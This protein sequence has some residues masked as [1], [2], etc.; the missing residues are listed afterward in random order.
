MRIKGPM[1]KNLLMKKTGFL[2][3]ILALICAMQACE[4]STQP[5]VQ[6]AEAMPKSPNDSLFAVNEGG[7]NFAIFLP[8]DLMIENEPEIRFNSATGDLHIRI[9]ER[10]WIVASQESKDISKLKEEINEN[11]LFTSRII[12]ETN[13]ALL[14]QR[15]L[16]DGRAYDYNYRYLS[17]IGGKPYF[18][19]TCEE[20]EYSKE[21]VDMMKSA[22]M[23]VHSRG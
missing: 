19:K 11:M 12:E 14:Y 9:G 21:S 22:I 3:T 18:F 23:S 16:P 5:A 17:S 10:F 1:N 2:L 6:Q 8:K 15:L 20:G 13:N 7:Y 4:T